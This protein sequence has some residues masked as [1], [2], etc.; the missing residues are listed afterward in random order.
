MEGRGLTRSRSVV[1]PRGSGTVD[2]ERPPGPAVLLTD[3]HQVGGMSRVVCAGHV[4][5]DV[6]LYVDALPEVDGESRLR[7][8]QAAGGGSAANV[9]TALVD[10]GLDSRVVGAVGDDELGGRVR[11]ELGDRGV[12]LRGLRT[13]EGG[14]TTEKYLIVDPAGQV[15]VLGNDG[16][17][18]ALTPGDVGRELL[19]GADHLH[20]TGQRP[21][22]ARALAEFAVDV[23]ASVSLDPGRRV[24][25]RDFSTLLSAVD[26]VFLNRVESRAVGERAVSG[27]G[28]LVVKYGEDGATVRA[29]GTRIAHPGYPVAAVDATGAG[30]AFAAGFLVAW[31]DGAGFERALAYGNACGAVAAEREGARADLDPERV[32]ALA[33]EES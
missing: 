14:E 33:A 32:A 30:D 31:L 20:L 21:E 13:V 11:E 15:C 23:G 4:N 22:T 10:L 27:D 7:A 25:D 3:R 17:N 28:A 5:W 18:E 9:A 16:V 12:D 26:V 1:T 2:G 8:R 19:A 6:T 29:D 24:A